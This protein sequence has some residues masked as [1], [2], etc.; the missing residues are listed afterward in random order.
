LVLEKH[1]FLDFANDEMVGKNKTGAFNSRP[2]EL[3]HLRQNRHLNM[4]I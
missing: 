3:E 4:S 1:S 2:E